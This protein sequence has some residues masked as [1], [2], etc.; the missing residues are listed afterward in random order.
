MILKDR[1][2][3]TVDALNE[4]GIDA[5]IILGRA[6][7]ILG[8]PSFLFLMPMGDLP[9]TCIIITKQGESIC[10]TTRLVSE[11]MEASGLFTKT[12]TYAGPNEL[13]EKIADAIKAMKQ[14]EKIAL[15]I[16]ADDASSDGLTHSQYL[17]IQECLKSAGYK[18]EIVSSVP[19]MKKVRGKKSLEEVRK[20]AHAVS[21][22]MKIYDE[23]RPYVK[24]GMSGYEVQSLFKKIAKS[25][26][27][28]FS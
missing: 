21:E 12:E 24:V 9:Q 22:S 20:I 7:N 4:N 19:I 26:G 14:M 2:S 5:W 3:R 16:S 6:T 11:E 27:Y 8:E 13:K 17:L 18:G 1:F 10:F 28:G 25:K 15:N 23:A